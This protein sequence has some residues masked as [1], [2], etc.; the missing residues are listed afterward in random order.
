MWTNLIPRQ[1]DLQKVQQLLRL[2][3]VTA[4]LGPRQVGK[5]T[6]AKAF[7]PDHSFDLENPRD[8]IALENPQ[9]TLEKLTGLI[10]I[11]KIQRKPSLF[12]LLRYLVDQNPAQK[13]LILGSA[14]STLRQQSNESLAGRIGNYFL[15][16]FNISE[17]PTENWHQLWVRGGF[18]RSYLAES[19]ADSLEWR[20]QFINTF[21]EK[22]LGMLAEGIPS[23]TM[24]RFWTML[25]HYHGQTLNYSE[26]G[27]SFGVSHNTVK[28][29][30]S[31]LEDTFMIRLLLPWH[32]NVK[33]RIVK[34]PKIYIRDAGIFHSLQ[35]I[36]DLEHLTTHP[37]LGASWEGFAL[38][39]L[40]SILQ[41]R[42]TELFFYGTH[43]GLELDLFWQSGGKSYGAEFKYKDAPTSTKSMH[44]AIEDLDLEHLWVIYPGDRKYALSEKITVLPLIQGAA[45]A[46]F[47]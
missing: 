38:E 43:G 9:L 32:A 22:D 18:P 35:G 20:N 19:N 5:T 31:I 46:P 25:S 28:R 14:S 29:Y 39:E 42:D 26:L 30:L 40:S 17:I 33:K 12:P 11:D 21:L 3:P 23:T 16:G 44:Q 47:S 41:K 34:A 2:F 7:E 45:L 24:Y 13:F 27:R 36:R 1:K 15:S 37:K 8:E 4:I 6:L 10:L